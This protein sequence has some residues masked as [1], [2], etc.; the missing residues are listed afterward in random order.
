MGML[1]VM[2]LM[3]VVFPDIRISPNTLATNPVAAADRTAGVRDE[4]PG[5]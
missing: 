2:M 1:L 4:Q 5:A 3:A